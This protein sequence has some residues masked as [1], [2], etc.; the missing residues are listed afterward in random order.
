VPSRS[1][2]GDVCVY[3][4]VAAP[5]A[6]LVAA[7]GEATVAVVRPDGY[8]LCAGGPAF[9]SGQLDRWFARWMTGA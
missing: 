3:T 4:H 9:V 1:R 8:L 6:A 7:M 5:S 2:Y